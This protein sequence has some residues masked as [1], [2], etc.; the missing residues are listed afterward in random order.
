ML[1]QESF[2]KPLAIERGRTDV[3][4]KIAPTQAITQQ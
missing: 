4:M 2:E 1:E 3:P